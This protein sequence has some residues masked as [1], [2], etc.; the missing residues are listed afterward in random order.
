[1]SAFRGREGPSP[2][3]CHTECWQPWPPEG[4]AP[5]L[6]LQPLPP[7]RLISRAAQLQK[8][9]LTSASPQDPTAR[10]GGSGEQANTPE[11]ATKGGVAPA[12]HSRTTFF[13][14]NSTSVSPADQKTRQ[15]ERPFMKVEVSHLGCPA[16]ARCPEHLPRARVGTAFTGEGPA[17]P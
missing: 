4:A 12:P 5:P 10:P 7:G 16:G 15:D 13:Y 6:L 11:M 2:P 8:P 17:P 14:F 9:Q 1:M 3:P